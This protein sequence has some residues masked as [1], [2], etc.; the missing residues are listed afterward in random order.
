[1]KKYCRFLEDVFD[2]DILVWK[3]DKNYEVSFEDD[4]QY[5]FGKP[6]INAIH[7]TKQNIL[8]KVICVEE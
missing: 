5:C 7:K 1:M 8:F 3:K 6:T 4:I 2:G